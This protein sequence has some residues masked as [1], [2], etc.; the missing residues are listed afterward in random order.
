MRLQ[1][2]KQKPKQVFKVISIAEFTCTEDFENW[3]KY[4][5]PQ[6]INVQLMPISVSRDGDEVLD[7][8]FSFKFTIVVQYW[9]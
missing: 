2:W 1:F 4:T 9:L 5:R 6:I 8:N 3:Q 7:E